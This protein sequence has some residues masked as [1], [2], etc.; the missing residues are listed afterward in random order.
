MKTYIALLRGINVGGHRPLKMDDL[1]QMFTMMGFEQVSTYIQSGNVVFD[2]SPQDENQLA[3]RIK[4]QIKDTFDY[5]VP[6][7]ICTATDLKT[8]LAQFPFEEKEGWKGYITFLSEEPSQELQDEL[9]AQSSSMEKFEVEN[10]VVYVHVDKQS[11]EKPKFSSNFI[12]KQ[13]NMPATNRNLRTAHKLLELA[14]N[15]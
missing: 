15:P 14:Q 7:I 9:E 5:D 10:G 1:R 12:Q 13:L 8:M 4:S 11:D 6:V 3:T 2:A